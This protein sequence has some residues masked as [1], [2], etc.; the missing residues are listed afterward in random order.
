MQRYT[1]LLLAFSVGL[2]LPAGARQ[3]GWSVRLEPMYVRTYGH[4]QHVLTIHERTLAPPVDRKTALTLDTRSGR[5]Y[6]GGVRY[7]RGRWAFGLDA[8]SFVTSHEAAPLSLA[9]GAGNDEVVLESADRTFVSTDAGEVLYYRLLEDNDI[10]V[11]TVDLYAIRKLAQ[12]DENRVGLLLGVRFADFDNDYR[13]VVGIEDTEGLRIDASSNYR[14][15]TGPLIGWEGSARIGR[16]SI[17]GVLAQSVVLGETVYDGAGREFTGAFGET[18]VF[19]SEETFRTPERVAI[20]ITEMRLR[21]LVSP[22]NRL[23]I[24]VGIHG[25]AWWDVGVPPGVL[26]VPAGDQLL[27]ENTLVFF[28]LMGV[29][30]VRF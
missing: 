29:V 28:G 2:T 13:A 26:P 18:P 21:A 22:F 3:T 6:R 17:E 25:S 20:P 1:F 11:W 15:M 12:S 30:E 8:F 19:V 14:R 16:F 24:G 23:A 4:D 5:G 7:S 10:A 9:A 27:Q